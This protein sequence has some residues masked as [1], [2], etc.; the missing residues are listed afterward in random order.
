MAIERIIVWG[1]AVCAGFVLGVGHENSAARFLEPD[2]AK[3]LTGAACPDSRCDDVVCGTGPDCVLNVQTCTAT[4]AV[5]CLKQLVTNFARCSSPGSDAGFSCTETSDSGC[6][7][8]MLGNIPANGKCADSN[9]A[10]P[11]GSCGKVLYTCTS[12]ACGS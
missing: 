4:G 2:V 3:S 11:T 10:V 5:T 1:L 6:R 8:I 7:T 12:T 9:C